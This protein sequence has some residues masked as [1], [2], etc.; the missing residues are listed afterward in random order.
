MKLKFL[1]INLYNT[2]KTTF[3]T[4]EKIGDN[5]KMKDIKYI[6]TSNKPSKEALKNFVL[7]AIELYNKYENNNTKETKKAS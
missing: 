7:S 6:V 2:N 4:K 3:L 1:K 5:K